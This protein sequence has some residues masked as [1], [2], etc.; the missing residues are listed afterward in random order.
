[1]AA[2]ARSFGVKSGHFESQEEKHVALA[3]GTPAPDF[4]LPQ[5]NGEPVTLSKLRG[6]P[7][8]LAFHPACFT[9]G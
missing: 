3:P 1:M 9:G 2:Y 7:V 6:R 5:H 8:V 4:T